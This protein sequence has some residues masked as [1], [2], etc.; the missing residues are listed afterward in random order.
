MK[1]VSG[2]ECIS[3]LYSYFEIYQF[4]LFPLSFLRTTPYRP[5]IRHKP[6]VH[7]W[8]QKCSEEGHYD[9]LHMILVDLVTENKDFEDGYID[10]SFIR[11]KGASEEV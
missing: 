6:I 9:M 10:A 2:S 1:K 5:I 3:V 11:T 7:Y 4:S 8:H